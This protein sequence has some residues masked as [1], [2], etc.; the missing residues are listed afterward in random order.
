[1]TATFV[2]PEL[3]LNCAIDSATACFAQFESGTE[4]PDES[5]REHAVHVAWLARQAPWVH[6]R[7]A[8]VLEEL[9]ARWAVARYVDAA[10]GL[11]DDE[12]L[13]RAYEP[14]ETARERV[15]HGSGR[16][17]LDELGPPIATPNAGRL[18]F[19]LGDR[20]GL[21]AHAFSYGAHDVAKHAIASA[22]LEG[23]GA[24]A[25][26]LAEHYHGQPNSDLRTLVGALD[27]LSQE[28]K[29][30]APLLEV[31]ASRAAKRTA[32]FSRNYGGVRVVLEACARWQNSTPPPLP[33]DAGAGELDR[34]EQ[35]MALG[36]RRWADE[37]DPGH[38]GLANGNAMAP[39]R[40]SVRVASLL[41]DVEGKLS[42]SE[43][44]TY[45]LEL[46]AL[47]TPWFDEGRRLLR[48]ARPLRSERSPFE[49]LPWSID[50][51]V[52]GDGAGEPFVMP[53][54]YDAAASRIAELAVAGDVDKELATLAAV[55]R[56][57]AA[58]GYALVGKAAQAEAALA[59]ALVELSPLKGQSQLARSSL[60][61]VLGDTARA[62]S[63]LE[64]LALGSAGDRAAVRLQR[65]QL[66]LPDVKSAQAEFRLALSDAAGVPV[67]F[68]RIRWWLAATGWQDLN[69][70]LPSDPQAWPRVG[71]LTGV[72]PAVRATKT[73]DALAVWQAWTTQ[74]AAAPE[75]MRVSRL[76]ALHARGVAPRLSLAPTLMLAAKLAPPDKAERWLDAFF[77]FDAER[78]PVAYQAWVRYLAAHGRGDEAAAATWRARFRTLM[79]YANEPGRAELWRAAG[80]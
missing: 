60:A 78:V 27:C 31:E 73:S 67:L 19:A 3:S 56:M 29:P 25:I 75:S 49:R 5:C 79:G 59:G 17:R 46:V 39:C 26:R 7:A 23:R 28:P 43:P 38:L 13:E 70:P 30:V 50:E 10:V 20:Q 68:D 15:E 12:A 71:L 4:A 72:S 58:R 77:A 47:L 52:W 35:R 22:L 61:W 48:L 55:L 57:Q 8:L 76:R 80:I 33:S 9:E 6:R 45:R 65:G 69:L 11:L 14:L 62:L 54:A 34:Y 64:P 51:W 41:S 40:S 74:A 63:A 36:L 44:L 2:L 21:D 37:C 16:L 32:N 1:M 53:E 66:L 42:G 18:A 24:R